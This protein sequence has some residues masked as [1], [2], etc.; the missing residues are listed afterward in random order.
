M[1][2]LTDHLNPGTVFFRNNAYSPADIR[3]GIDAIADYL[4]RSLPADSPFV[5]LVAINHIKTLLAYFGIIKSGHVCVL[6][7]PKIGRLEYDEMLADTPPAAICRFDPSTIGF[8]FE[9]EVELRR[10]AARFDDE[11]ENVCT[12][13]YTA[14]DDGY[15]K[16]AM[17]THEN[18]LVNALGLASC[19]Q[20]N[21][22][23]VSCSLLPYNHLYSLQSGIIAPSLSRES[24]L[25]VDSN[26]FRNIHCM[27]DE[28]IK[29]KV[30]T[31]FAVPQI[32]YLLIKNNTIMQGSS[33]L[34]SFVCGGIK[35][36]ATMIKII[37]KKC[38]IPIR[39]GYGLTEASPVCTGHYPGERIRY[40][41][42]GVSYGWCE[43]DIVDS[44]DTLLPTGQIGEVCIRGRNVM[45][46]Y[47]RQPEATAKALCRH[48][49]LHT[50]DLG[51]IDTD[52]YLFLTGLKKRMF[53]VAG[54]KVFP[55]EVERLIRI[56]DNVASVALYAEPDTIQGQKISATV[57]LKVDTPESREHF[58]TWC[59]NSISRYKIPKR[60]DFPR[61]GESELL[62]EPL[63]VENA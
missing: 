29:R 38:T 13:L 58:K 43:I 6:I 12:M 55:A 5:Y 54:K 21:K 27:T 57:T 14:A 4:Q 18:I 48:G 8:D 40:N 51:R 22:T 24:I 60:I 42:V 47:Y 61:E 20:M 16:A 1:N 25:I 41:S 28:I 53:N 23:G 17:L 30:S 2:K 56:N 45:K 9:N 59:F 7:D 44:H 37:S 26:G 39:E 3:A 52:G 49:H 63:M 36:S 11:L 32:Y 31:I 10:G 35:L 50:G 33:S 19:N 15:A 46:G 62:Y 34:K